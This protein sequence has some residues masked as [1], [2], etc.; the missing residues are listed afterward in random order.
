ML[1]VAGAFAILSAAQD[2][3]PR[4]FFLVGL[5]RPENVAR[6]GALAI[7]VL[8]MASALVPELPNIASRV[9]RAGL[10]AAALVAAA[11]GINAWINAGMLVENIGVALTMITASGLLALVSAIT[12]QSDRG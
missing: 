7:G 12:P 6:F 8:M 4:P 1:M 3:V 5:E 10:G 11:A 9:V 2:W